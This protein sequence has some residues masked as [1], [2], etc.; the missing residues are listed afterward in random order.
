MLWKVGTYIYLHSRLKLG[1]YA[2]LCKTSRKSESQNE[3]TYT[4][5][6]NLFISGVGLGRQPLILYRD[7]W[8]WK[9]STGFIDLAFAR[10]NLNSSRVITGKTARDG[11]TNWLA[12]PVFRIFSL[13]LRR[14]IMGGGR[15]DGVEQDD[16]IDPN[17]ILALVPRSALH[18]G[19]WGSDLRRRIAGNM[20]D[21]IGWGRI[22]LDLSFYV[23]WRE[24]LV[25]AWV[26]SSSISK[27]GKTRL[28]VK[29]ARGV[30]P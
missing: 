20:H 2:T 9:K 13:F 7:G 19:L 4:S 16:M 18:W 5:K 27:K 22:I 25:F 29:V 8:R 24:E 28:V 21:S 11:R 23:V 1:I 26:S 6:N 12:H 17:S 10:F 14:V 15:T 30:L 3:R